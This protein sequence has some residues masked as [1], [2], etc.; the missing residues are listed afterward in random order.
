[1][2]FYFPHVLFFFSSSLSPCSVTWPI[3]AVLVLREYKKKSLNI[4]PCSF[5]APEACV[6]ASHP[7]RPE[8]DYWIYYSP[9][10]LQ[11][12]LWQYLTFKNRASCI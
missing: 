6:A 11:L 9:G 1:L 8:Y 4:K 7:R 2:L 12:H 3:R 5:E 10:T